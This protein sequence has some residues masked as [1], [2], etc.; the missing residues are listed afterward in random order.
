[1]DLVVENNQE[2]D[3]GPEGRGF[4]PA[5]KPARERALAPEATHLYSG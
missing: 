3:H 1:M 2:I 5:E 4:S